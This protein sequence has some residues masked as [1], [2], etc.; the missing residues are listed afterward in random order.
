VRKNAMW[1]LIL[2][3]LVTL[4]ALHY[5]LKP[6]PTV[7]DLGDPFGPQPEGL[8]GQAAP[9]FQVRPL[10]AEPFELA[11][12]GAGKD[13]LVHFTG[14]R[15]EACKEEMKELD[16]FYR[17]RR[18]TGLIVIALFSNSEKSEVE[19]FIRDND[20]RFPVALDSE[21]TLTSRFG[22]TKIP[23][24]VL[25]GRNGKIKQLVIGQVYN[26]DIAFGDRIGKND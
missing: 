6:S 24:S 9:N 19:R 8:T 10:N 17:A 7:K 25:V 21:R 16:R 23:S 15:R 26:A 20:I 18:D 2:A 22:V 1:L 11:G 13:V 3:S 12:N 14:V 5:R 4:G